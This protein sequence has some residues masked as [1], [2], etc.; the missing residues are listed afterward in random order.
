MSVNTFKTEV[1]PFVRY[2]S[3][4]RTGRTMLFPVKELEKWLERRAKGL[5]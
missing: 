1:R 3:A 5:L 4:G 2:A